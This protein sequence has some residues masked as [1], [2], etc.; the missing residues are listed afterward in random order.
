MIVM[1]KMLP[2]IIM[3]CILATICI[4]NSWFLNSRLS[5][6]KALVE[7]SLTVSSEKAYG[8]LSECSNKWDEISGYA[9]F[10]LRESKCDEIESLIIEAM[11]KPA[12][13]SVKAKLISQIDAT[14]FMESISLSSIF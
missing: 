12:D 7:E 3:I 2:G 5:N 11:N 14:I 8:K 13:S 1:K 4:V 6:M 10:V 9:N